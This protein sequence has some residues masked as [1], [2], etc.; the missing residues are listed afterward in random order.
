MTPATVRRREGRGVRPRAGHD[1]LGHPRDPRGDRGHQQRRRQRVAAGRDVAADALERGHAL[2]DLDPSGDRGAPSARELAPRDAADVAGRG[3]QR[4]PQLRGDGLEPRLHLLRRHLDGAVEVV[5]APRVAQHRLVAGT[6]DRAHDTRDPAGEAGVDVVAAVDQ[7]P[8]RRP[9]RRVYD[10]HRS[11]ILSIGNSA[12]SS[13][14]AAWGRTAG[15]SHESMIRI[16]ARSRS[17]GARRCPSARVAL[18]LGHP[19]HS[20]ISSQGNSTIPSARAALGFGIRITARSCSGGTRRFPPPASPSASE[21][22]RAPTT[23]R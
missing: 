13:V 12:L 2:L 7:A 9:I 5:E 14:P 20:T 8:D 1:D 11:T 18:G 3:P 22:A 21:S 17:G 23:P 15:P 16:T 4:R 10:P 19:H 6:P